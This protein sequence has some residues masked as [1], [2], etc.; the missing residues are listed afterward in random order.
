MFRELRSLDVRL[1][2]DGERLR[3]NAPRGALSA[4]LSARIAKHKK[5]LIEFLRS[6]KAP[7]E[8]DSSA[9]PHVADDEP[10]PLSFAQERL[11]FLEQLEPGRPVYNLS[12]ALRIDGPLQV[13]ALEASFNRILGRHEALRTKFIERGGRL[14]QA[15]AQPRPLRL[16]PIDLSALSEAER[17]S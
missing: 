9:I 6:A 5:T 4:A 13:D 8:T 3:I 12:R 10:T 15:I 2:V 1:S 17:A 7:L 16:K 11:W 14:F